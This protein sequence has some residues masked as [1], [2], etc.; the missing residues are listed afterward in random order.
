[1][2]R[3]GENLD[4]RQ[5]LLG[6][7]HTW[8]GI[9]YVEVA[10]PDQKTLRVHF[11]NEVPVTLGG[12]SGSPP[13][14][15]TPTVT[16]TGGE[17]IT[18]VAA[19][20]IDEA[21][22]WS[23]D[24]QARPVLTVR[25]KAPGDFSTY[26]LALVSQNLDPYFAKASFSF[27][28]NCPSDFDCQQ[29]TTH[30][31]P[32]DALDLP[33]DYL[34]KDFKSFVQALSEFS[35][36][37]YPAWLE[38]SEADIGMVVMELIAAM[39]DE[40]SYYQDRIAGESVLGTAT[41][42]RS[43][44]HAA[45]L[46]DYE[47]APA[48]T[49]SV[50]LQLDVDT[51]T[52]AI[53]TP[54]H[55]QAPAAVG[56]LIDFEVG[57]GLANPNTGKLAPIN[58]QVAAT[59]NRKRA[60]GTANLQ[61]YWWDE[62]QQCLPAGSTSFD[63]FGQGFGLIAGQ[64]LLIDTAGPTTADPPVREIV[65]TGKAATEITDPVFNVGLTR[66]WLAAPTTVAH[67]LTRTVYAGNLVPATQGLR[68][69]ETFTIPADSGGP[70]TALVRL[71]P[72]WT[73]KDPTPEYF[74]CLSSGPLAWL[75]STVNDA[76]TAE[77]AR[78]EMVL[79]RQDTAWTWARWLLDADAGAP[80][81]TLTPE[82][83]SPVL[84]ASRYTGPGQTARHTWFDYDGGNG[85]TIRFG[86][87]TFGALPTPGETFQALYRV[88]GG[89]VG[90][91]AADAITIVVPG[92]SSKGVLS[93]T[94]PFPAS[95]GTDAETPQQVRDRAPQAFAAKPLRVVR[96]A[97]YVAAAESLPWVQQA[98]TTFRWTGSWLT[99]MNAADP[100]ATEQPTP[101]EVGGLTDLLNRRRL[102]GYESYVLA[103]RYVSVDL[104]ITLCAKPTY[105]ASDVEAAVLTA[106]RPGKLPGGAVGFFDHSR[107]GFGA[108][109]ESSA[110]LAAVQDCT[111]V[112]G[113][114][115]VLF[116]QRGVQITW[117]ALPDTMTVGT[118]QILR[119]DDD[120]SRPEAGSLK[121]TVKGGK[122]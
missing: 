78:P 92:T 110:L 70:Q 34:A 99:V 79:T 82:Q 54:V 6:L 73:P 98:G 114:S 108:P 66:V 116:R 55:C 103:P 24:D 104:H 118:D 95:G 81:F 109:L 38:R 9:D 111:G 106:L 48:T 37:R 30:C 28:A 18:S 65:T 60:D 102:A 23:V 41:Q 85:T 12:A 71:G 29:P 58:Y 121:V 62:S 83:Y 7:A 76:D 101:D 13:S 27:K 14:G 8:N 19:L 63:I 86:N 90:N 113:V 115:Q 96:P 53:T 122:A 47:P 42:P 39:G 119:V 49:A 105:F 57:H 97:D 100:I 17:V 26:Q 61:P 51:T 44:L 87:G 10:S 107:W 3:G 88:G 31:P 40:L 75:G 35:T 64:Q 11:L 74:Y 50:Q 77:P 80:S 68:T 43:L 72:N 52:T 69:T 120:P 4:R 16:I 67:D 32:P 46:V 15:T 91:V 36:Q 1:M 117:T 2:T 84:T 33:I 94:N 89:S 56:G 20:P 21:T 93:C 45:R 112:A 5:H 59:W 22:D 25:V